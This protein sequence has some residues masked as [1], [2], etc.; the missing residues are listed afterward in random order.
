MHRM[1]TCPLGSRY[2][3]SGE[4]D[5]PLTSR[6]L[7]VGDQVVDKELRRLLHDRVG[8]CEEL[9]IRT[10]LLVLPEMLYQPRCARR[11]QTRTR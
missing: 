3:F 9:A 2:R 8:P 6:P 11:P 5:G 7:R 10:E 1:P 4:T